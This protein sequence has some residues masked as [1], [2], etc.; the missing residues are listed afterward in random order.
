MSDVAFGVSLRIALVM[1]FAF[2]SVCALVFVG[3]EVSA[4]ALR[5]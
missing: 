3:S 1:A 2:P 4:G 5:P